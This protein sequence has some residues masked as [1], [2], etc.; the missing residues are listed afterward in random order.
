MYAEEEDSE[1]CKA[2]EESDGARPED[3]DGNRLEMEDDSP[4]E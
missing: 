2:L 1:T 4:F 3:D